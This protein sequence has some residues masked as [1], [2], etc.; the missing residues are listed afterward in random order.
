MK[1]KQQSAQI[2]QLC[3]I[4]KP[5][6]A[7]A[8]GVLDCGAGFLMRMRI[9]PPCSSK[10]RGRSCSPSRRETA[11][12]GNKLTEDCQEGCHS[13]SYKV[14]GIIVNVAVL[15]P[16]R[17]VFYIVDTQ[18]LRGRLWRCRNK[19]QSHTWWWARAR[20]VRE[21]GKLLITCISQVHLGLLPSDTCSWSL[22]V[23]PW[24]WFA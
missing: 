2:K 13:Q 1:E 5:Y 6:L 18:K 7:S 24:F 17:L 15:N 23:F 8:P 9:F 21:E 14:Y 11:G 10:H 4:N 12:S 22:S 3:Y 16:K 20:V 19:R